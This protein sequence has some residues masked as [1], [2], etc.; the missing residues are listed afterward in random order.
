MFTDE[1]CRNEVMRE[2]ANYVLDKS[3]VGFRDSLTQKYLDDAV[4]LGQAYAADNTGTASSENGSGV[5]S[6][7]PLVA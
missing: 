1:R 7:L 4:Q 5:R 2:D 3:E 6:G